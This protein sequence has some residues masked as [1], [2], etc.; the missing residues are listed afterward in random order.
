MAE[1]KNMLE[2]LVKIE[3]CFTVGLLPRS[4]DTDL[5]ETKEFM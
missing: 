5:S 2:S 1:D 4:K 3:D